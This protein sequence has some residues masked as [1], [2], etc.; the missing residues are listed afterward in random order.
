MFSRRLLT[1]GFENRTHLYLVYYPSWNIL[2]E[3]QVEA[4]SVSDRDWILI[5][6]KFGLFVVLGLI[7][8]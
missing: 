3:K 7:G 6:L 2:N 4:V 1:C 5:I 8:L